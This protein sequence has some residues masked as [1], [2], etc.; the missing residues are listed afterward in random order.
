VAYNSTET[1][2]VG[3]CSVGVGIA[4]N[5]AFDVHFIVGSNRYGKLNP[6]DAAKII[7]EDVLDNLKAAQ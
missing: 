6:C 3:D 1:S 7:A 5:L 4:D 2:P